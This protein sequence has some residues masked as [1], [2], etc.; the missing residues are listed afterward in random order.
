MFK[1]T[2]FFCPEC[3]YESESNGR[4]PQCEVPLVSE[5]QFEDDDEGNS[6][7]SPS[8]IDPEEL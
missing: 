2:M 5:Q 7:A 6:E 8:D 4:C 1:K 3:D